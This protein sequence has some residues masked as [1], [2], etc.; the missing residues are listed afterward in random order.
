MQPAY[1]ATRGSAAARGYGRRW[2]AA[3]A[4]FL[5]RHPVCA[6]PDRCG[7]PA[8]EVDHRVPHRGDPALFWDQANWQPLTRECHARKTAAEG[9]R[10]AQGGGAKG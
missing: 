4:A 5:A 2:Q 7:R 3:R 8:T 6:C 9:P 1:D 10:P